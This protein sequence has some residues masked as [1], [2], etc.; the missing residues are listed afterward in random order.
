MSVQ[1]SG[2][3]Y[4]HTV[5]QLSQPSISRTFLTKLSFAPIKTVVVFACSALGNPRT[6]PF[7]VSVRLACCCHTPGRATGPSA[8]TTGPEEPGDGF[9]WDTWECLANPVTLVLP[10]QVS[11]LQV[12]W[13]FPG[14]ASLDGQY[15]SDLYQHRFCSGE[16]EGSVSHQHHPMD[17]PRWVRICFASK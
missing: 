4:I 14:P 1:F 9:C 12:L 5:V 6:Q 8:P 10:L 3:K 13:R 16:R 11:V 2:T 15:H 17:E 7:G